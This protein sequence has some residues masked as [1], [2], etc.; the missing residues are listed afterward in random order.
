MKGP[1]I[2]GDITLVILE[3][4]SKIMCQSWRLL[5]C[6]TA[7]C[8]KE[9]V[10]VM[11]WEIPEN[12]VGVII[13]NNRSNAVAAFKSHFEEQEMKRNAFCLSYWK[14]NGRRR[15]GIQNPVGYLGW[16]GYTMSIFS[17]DTLITTPGS[18]ASIQ[19]TAVGN[20]ISKCNRLADKTWSKK[21]CCIF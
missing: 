6:H 18:S 10:E 5:S 7:E 16:V 4:S 21:C 9:V 14:W 3:W 19:S 1:L 17:I 2:W 11:E 13:S 15:G 8:V 20:A 12:K